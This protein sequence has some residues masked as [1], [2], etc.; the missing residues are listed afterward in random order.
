MRF[1]L[2]KYKVKTLKVV[3]IALLCNMPFILFGSVFSLKLSFLQVGFLL[4]LLQ[5]FNEV[6]WFDMKY[7]AD[8]VLFDTCPHMLLFEIHVFIVK[9]VFPRAE[10]LEMRAALA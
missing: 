3:S 8:F 2:N 10:Q 5:L 9:F 4:I 1:I 7:V 6:N